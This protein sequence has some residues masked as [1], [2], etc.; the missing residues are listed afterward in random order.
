MDKYIDMRIFSLNHGGIS[1][2]AVKDEYKKRYNGISTIRL[3]FRING[4]NAFVVYTNEIVNSISSIYQLNTKLTSELQNVPGEAYKEYIIQSLVEEIQQSNEVEHVESTRQEIQKAYDNKDQKSLRFTGMVTK[5]NL[6]LSK[7][8]IR[9][10]TSSDIRQL[11]DDFILDEVV[12]ENPKDYPDGEI[13]R[14]EPVHVYGKSIDSLHD[15][16]YPESRFI[17]AMEQALHVLQDDD[18][19]L[20]IRTAI[21]HFMFGYIHPFYNGNGRMSRFISSYMLS[22]SID[23]AICLR[24][25]YVIKE[26]KNK[27]LKI[28]KDTEDARNL[29]DLTGF[30]IAFLNMIESACYDVTSDIHE[31]NETYHV[32]KTKL[33]EFLHAADSD[34]AEKYHNIFHYILEK[35][36]FI[37]NG[38]SFDDIVNHTHVTKATLYKLFVKSDALVYK[39]KEGREYRW[40]VKL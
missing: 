33:D 13:F 6:L 28:F 31:K 9:L 35:T 22:K 34:I 2:Q 23:Q 40:F 18:L 8:D 37:G 4:A 10:M 25:S 1:S 29:G 36:I 5:Y 15:G 24:L 19:N 16:L 20:L 38:A 14:K 17:E 12:R 7:T 30:V 21:F 3:P 32:M 39:R 11:Y 26:K 27:Y